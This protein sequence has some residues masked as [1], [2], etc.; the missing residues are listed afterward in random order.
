MGP[1]TL[2]AATVRASAFSSLNEAV[3]RLGDTPTTLIMDGDLPVQSSVIC[4]AHI[5]IDFSSQG[6]RL[7]ASSE[8]T[9]DIRGGILGDR[10]PI[11]SDSRIK[12][13]GLSQEVHPDWFYTTSW[14]GAIEAAS[15][16]GQVRLLP[17]D[18]PIDRRIRLDS[19]CS[20]ITGAGLAS[21]LILGNQVNDTIMHTAYG[22][23]LALKAFC[24]DGNYLNNQ[25]RRLASHGI[26]VDRGT[27]VSLDNV[28][29]KNCAGTGIFVEASTRTR[30]SNCLVD[31]AV[32]TS[33]PI[34]SPVWDCL[35]I[36]ASTFNTISGCT[37]RHGVSGIRAWQCSGGPT[38]ED[39]PSGPDYTVIANC[40]VFNSVDVGITIATARFCSVTGNLVKNCKNHGF[41]FKNL[42]DSTLCGN[43][44]M[45]NSHDGLMLSDYSSFGEGYDDLARYKTGGDSYRSQRITIAGNV[46]RENGHDGFNLQGTSGAS[47]TGNLMADNCRVSRGYGGMSITAC[48]DIM[49]QGNTFLNTSGTQ[50]QPINAVGSDPTCILGRNHL[51]P[52]RPAPL[53]SALPGAG[54]LFP[55]PHPTDP[56]IFKPVVGTAE[57]LSIVADPFA[58]NGTALVLTDRSTTSNV[59]VK[60]LPIRLNTDVASELVVVRAKVT[61]PTKKLHL[62]L[63]MLD[64]EGRS[65]GFVQDNLFTVDPSPQF[66]STLSFVLPRQERAASLV[67]WIG[68]PDYE[69]GA[70]VGQVFVDEISVWSRTLIPG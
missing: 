54:Q 22:N 62:R 8:V 12:I 50:A 56:S 68:S 16:Q 2:T 24:L 1:A 69:T 41:E 4:P 19:K 43:I 63:E 44:S 31:Q 51:G 64:G 15:S 67:V 53:R 29:V 32:T 30:I 6:G 3:A 60:T 10:R 37:F 17:R 14:A 26:H 28:V 40:Q 52:D 18:Y 27:D 59:L 33:T 45:G 25:P 42:L 9:V 58:P 34:E 35:Q 57:N 5:R 21:R 23:E 49:V 66:Y 48:R 39:S 61:H 65:L 46:L 55:N 38:G 47:V 36:Y 13:V 7:D 70:E 20:A 11:I